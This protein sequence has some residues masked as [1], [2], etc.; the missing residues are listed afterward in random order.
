MWSYNSID[1]S[2]F[3]IRR[4][5]VFNN[6]LSSIRLIILKFGHTY[7]CQHRIKVLIDLGIITLPVSKQEV[8]RIQKNK[9]YLICCEHEYNIKT[10]SFSPPINGIVHIILTCI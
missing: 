1:V 3:S 5:N 8:H 10:A 9:W 2:L 4:H 6:N 7:P